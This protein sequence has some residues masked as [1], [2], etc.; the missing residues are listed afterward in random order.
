[1]KTAMH[2]WLPGTAPGCPA[3]FGDEFTG[4][5]EIVGGCEPCQR[6]VAARLATKP[7]PMRPWIRRLVVAM[8]AFGIRRRSGYLPELRAALDRS[9]PYRV[10]LRT[11]VHKH[12]QARCM[13]EDYEYDFGPILIAVPGGSI[14]GYL[15]NLS[16]RAFILKPPWISASFVIQDGHPD[17][18]TIENAVAALFSQV[19]GEWQ[20]QKSGANGMAVPS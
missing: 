10:E 8:I 9:F 13:S 17:E 5:P 3:Q 16:R 18:E 7:A 1:M 20:R 2:W 19:T 14:G 6:Y 4:N 15:L 11:L 12:V